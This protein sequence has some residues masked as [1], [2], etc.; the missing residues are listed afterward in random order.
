VR[1][2]LADHWAEILGLQGQQ[3]NEGRKVGGISGRGW[4][5]IPWLLKNSGFLKI[6]SR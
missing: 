4:R 5:E 3:V 1:D 2:G 6:A